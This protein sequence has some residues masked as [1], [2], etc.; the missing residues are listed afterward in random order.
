[1]TTTKPEKK[2]RAKRR[3][4][5]RDKAAPE[6]KAKPS[7]KKN[8]KPQLNEVGLPIRSPFIHQMGVRLTDEE[9]VKLIERGRKE[10][11]NSFSNIIRAALGFDTVR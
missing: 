7:G 11:H 1:M 2:K 8:G 4:K 5:R 3:A 6:V 9:R 10:G